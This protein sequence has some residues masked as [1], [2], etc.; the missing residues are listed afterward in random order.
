MAG[1]EDG[2]ICLFN[3]DGNLIRPLIGH[4]NKI[5]N[6]IWTDKEMIIS[7]SNDCTIR[8]WSEKNGNCFGIF[9]FADPIS[10]AIFLP[11]NNILYTASWDKSI[12]CLDLESGEIVKTFVGSKDVIKCIS[13]SNEVIYVAG[14]DPVIRGFNITTGEVKM[15]EGHK[16]WVYCIEILD[17]QM[18]SGSDDQSVIVWDIKTTKI[19]QSLKGHSNGVTTIGFTN[20][21]MYT[22]SY[23]WNI[24][25]WSLEEIQNRIECLEDMRIADQETIKYETYW[26]ILDA[27]KGKKKKG[28]KKPANNKKAEGNSEPKEGGKKK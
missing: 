22:G 20:N 18:F 6:L 16:S 26:R 4:T 28:V 13:Y 10:S 9:K 7:T 25:W 23:D 8:Q 21:D 3:N 1:Y 17:D 14:C 5:N 24:I 12:R 27:K 2:L 19:L 11:I 15:Y